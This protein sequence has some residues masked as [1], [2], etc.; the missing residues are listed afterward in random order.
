MHWSC[1]HKCQKV[2]PPLCWH[3]FPLPCSSWVP[4]PVQGLRIL[5]IS[6]CAFSL[7]W[8]QAAGCVDHYKVNLLPNQGK[9][10]MHPARDGF[11][12]VHILYTK[13]N[14]CW[15][16]VKISWDVP[17]MQTPWQQDCLASKHF[18]SH[19]NNV[20]ALSE[21]CSSVTMLKRKKLHT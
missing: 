20:M 7:R 5:N 1:L 18:S 2:S 17:Q 9:I 10:T 4:A 16:N 13:W 11:I 15:L 14:T 12:Q 8:E 19:Q 6:A 21:S 3:C